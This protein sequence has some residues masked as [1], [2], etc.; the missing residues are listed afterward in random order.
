M[1]SGALI[2]R[3]TALTIPALMLRA[4]PKG[5][6]IATTPAPGFTREELPSASGRSFDVA[7]LTRS[8]ATSAATSLPRR[9]TSACDPSLKPTVIELASSTTC[10]FVTMSPFRSSTKPDPPPSTSR[11]PKGV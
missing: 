1:S 7:L 10:S 8:T 3:P 4:S 2:V 6:P 5:L 11:E 9:L